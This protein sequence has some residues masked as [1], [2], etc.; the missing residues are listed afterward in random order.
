MKPGNERIRMSMTHRIVVPLVL[1]VALAVSGAAPQPARAAAQLKLCGVVGLHVPATALLPG[2]LTVGGAPFLIAAGTTLDSSVAL[3]ANLCFDL[4]LSLGGL[5]TAATV[6][7]NTSSTLAVCGNVTAYT[8]ASSTATGLLTIN[9][10]TF[11]VA[12]ATALPATVAIGTAPCL[13][14]TL[15]GFGQ[16]SGA[17]AQANVTSILDICG[18]VSSYTPATSTSA[19]AL[20]IAGRSFGVAVGTTLPASVNAGAA[21]CMHLTLN[22]LAQVSGATAQANV[23][24][25]LEVCGRV[26]AYTAASGTA[27][28][29][30]TTAGT[31]HV[32]AAGASLSPTIQVNAYL[33]LRMTLD[34]IARIADAAV[35][36]V[37]G[38]LAEACGSSAPMSTAP[39]GTPAPTSS[40]DA[41]GM[42]VPTRT[43]APR[44]T[45]DPSATPD[46][47]GFLASDTG[48]H[49]AQTNGCNGGDAAAAPDA[50]SGLGQFLPDTASLGRAGLAVLKVSLPLLLLLAGLIGRELIV[51]RARPATSGQRAG[52]EASHDRS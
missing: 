1:L 49:C 47:T 26:S 31:T 27:N 2:A 43:P 23:T 16:I 24:S 50:R 37:G 40:P 19:G 38:S 41:S 13:Q 45:L 7:A 22:G 36:K 33:K 46:P 9:S 15:N 28:G 14:L 25:A 21:L 17:T 10:A 6:T 5:I 44:R 34:A 4:T 35:L 52:P 48:T 32:I 18:V 3:N 20:T 11:V 51:R 29:S 42:P 30:L 39:S 8:A 12:I